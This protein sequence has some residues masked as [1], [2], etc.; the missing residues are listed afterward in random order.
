MIYNA[1]YDRITFLST[2]NY[3]YEDSVLAK[4]FDGIAPIV[5]LKFQDTKIKMKLRLEVS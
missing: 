1:Y 3:E 2:L 5:P 4:K